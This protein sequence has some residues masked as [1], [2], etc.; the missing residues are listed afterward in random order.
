MLDVTI[1]LTRDA[2]CVAPGAVSI[3]PLCAD[4]NYAQIAQRHVADSA[5]A[6]LL[7]R[8]ISVDR[9]IVSAAK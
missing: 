4:R 6:R 7:A 9:D 3:R 1:R 8:S 5:P 2:I